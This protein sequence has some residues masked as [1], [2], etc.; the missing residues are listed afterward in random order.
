MR[1]PIL[2]TALLATILVTGAATAQEAKHGGRMVLTYK[3]DISTLDPAIG[4]DWQNPS[5]MQAIFD[6]LMDYRPG[7]FELVP[8]LAES[9]TV[10]DAG[11]T[12]TFKLR[13]GVKFHN[14]REMTA[15]DVRYS[16]ERILN[17]ATQSPAQGYFNV[18]AGSD[19]F[20]TKGGH[21]SGIAL[22]DPYTVSITLKQAKATFLN[23]LAMHFGSVVPKEEVDKYSAD[24]GHHPVGT[25]AFKLVEWTPGQHLL[26]QRNKAYFKPDLPHL[27]EVEI[28]VGQDPSV[29]LLRLKKGEVDLTGDGIPPAQFQSV[30]ADPA[31]KNQVIAGK[32]LQTSYLALNTQVPPLDD[33]RVRRAINMAINK[34]RIVRIINNRAVPASQPLPPRMPGYDPNYKGYPYDPE[35]AKKLL[36]EAGHPNGF[37]TTLYSINTD[38]NPRIAQ[39]IQQDLA[40]IGIKAELKALASSVVIQAGGTPKEAPMIWSGGMAWIADFPD[41]SGFYWTILGCGGAT[42]GGWNWA[43]YCNNE[44]DERAAKADA[45]VGAGESATRVQIWRSIFLDVMKDAPWVPIFH[46]DFY[47]VHSQRLAGAENYFVS[48]TH[49]PIYYEMLYATDAQ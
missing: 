36:S 13:H 14:G 33:V 45:M 41:P 40:Q 35:G 16:F 9:Y 26:L 18:I 20:A 23:V 21:V 12:Y 37:E 15:E 47:T 30:I 42:Q 17:P 8:D 27:D 31:L 1:M 11:R 49:I 4:Y 39:A 6:G 32:Q 48:P 46:E 3:D 38:P 44:I 34:E 43:W 10:S 2:G 5:I 29:S 19:E 22:S 24:F 25:G 7:T 28:Q